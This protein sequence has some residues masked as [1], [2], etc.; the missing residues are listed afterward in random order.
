MGELEMFDRVTKR[1]EE[2]GEL[3]TVFLDGNH[4]T[5]ERLTD[6]RERLKEQIYVRTLV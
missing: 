4:L 2:S 3:K 6:I 1:A 5:E